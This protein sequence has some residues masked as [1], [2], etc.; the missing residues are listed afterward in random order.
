MTYLLGAAVG[1]GRP[2][3]VL[4]LAGALL[5]PFVGHALDHHFVERVPGHQHANL[6]VALA[7]HLHPFETAHDHE[8]GAGL[9]REGIVFLPP[10]EEGTAGQEL[11]STLPDLPTLLGV[12]DVSVLILVQRI[13]GPESNT[14]APDPPPPRISPLVNPSS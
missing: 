5:V 9:Q 8:A 11:V 12:L 13:D 7:D 14:I 10:G 3:F 2:A 6:T 4:L 1:V